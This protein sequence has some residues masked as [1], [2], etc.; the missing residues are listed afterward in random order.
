MARLLCLSALLV[1]LLTSPAWT[2]E[3]EEK[4]FSSMVNV[5]PGVH[6]IKTDDKGRITSCVVVGQS[7]ISTVLGKSKGLE[8]ARQKARL[9]ANGQFTKW[10][11]E[12]TS[13]HEKDSGE[14]VL[15]LEG[16]EGN[17]KDAMSESGKS[18]EKTSKNIESTAQAQL[19][20]MQMLHV[21]QNGAEKTITIVMG[22]DAK[23]AKA[24]RGARAAN[25][26]A[27]A[28]KSGKNKDDDTNQNADDAK[29]AIE[30][31]KIA[32]KKIGDKKATSSGA[33][34]FIP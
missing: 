33:K 32:E 23:T 17:D 3:A 24:I 14:T 19:R 7:R 4:F 20:G 5:G 18:V 2:D 31:K 26:D 12:K 15:F 21:D 22:W 10:L 29:K 8:L 30:D 6:A 34:K 16:S 9:D 27:P 1:T 28:N 11:G 25:E 13:I